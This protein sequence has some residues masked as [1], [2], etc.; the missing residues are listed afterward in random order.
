MSVEKRG[1]NL[2]QKLLVSTCSDCG[3]AW[4]MEV[5]GAVAGGLE[6]AGAVSG[7]GMTAGAGGPRWI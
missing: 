3:V 1:G 4:V 5:W 6:A 7:G 2:T